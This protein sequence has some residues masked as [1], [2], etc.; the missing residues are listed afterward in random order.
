M[1]NYVLKSL[2][3]RRGRLVL[4]LVAVVLGVAFVA[5]SLLFTGQLRAQ[6]A[7]LTHGRTPD[8]VVAPRGALDPERRDA[9]AGAYSP[10][11]V[12][13]VANLPG[14]RAAEGVLTVPGVG[15]DRKD[16]TT[17]VNPVAP[18][19]AMGWTEFTVATGEPALTLA[20]GRAPAAG[21]VVLDRATWDAAGYR[22]GDRVMFALPVDGMREVALRV[23]GVGD[24]TAGANETQTVFVNPGQ[25][26][27]WVGDA[28]RTQI[29]AQ[30]GDGADAAVVTDAID[31]AL[32]GSE[33]LTA[34][35][36]ADL[37]SSAQADALSFLQPLLL[38]FAGIALV[39]ACFLIVNTFSILVLQRT[40]ELALLRALGASRGQV[41]RIVVLEA[42][43]VGLVGS[44]LG[45]LAGWGLAAGLLALMG[46]SGGLALS[47]PVLMTGIGVGLVVTLLASLPPARRA[48]RIAPVVAM[49]GTG[50]NERRAAPRHT[51]TDE[52]PVFTKPLGR[53]A[54]LN[55][56][57]RPGRTVA[58]A[59]TL[60]IGLFLV[61]TLGT[62]G[63]SMKATIDDLMPQVMTSDYMVSAH[64]GIGS[65][66][67]ARIRAIDGVGEVRT[68]EM[69]GAGVGDLQTTVTA[70][71][72]EAYGHPI[73]QTMI[74]GRPAEQPGELVVHEPLLADNGWQ[75][76][77]H[78]PGMVNGVEMTWT[79]VG[80][81]AY[82]QNISAGDFLTAPATLREL[83]IPEEIA[84]V[85]V[86]AR[87]GA[88]VAAI[89]DGLRTATRQVSGAEVI[90]LV[91][92][93]ELAGA[94]INAL[95]GG[96]Y[97]LIALSVLIA[98]LGIVNT[99]G[100]SVVERTR[101]LGL[102]RA[103]GMTRG[104]VRGLIVRESLMISVIGGTVGIGL[105]V[106]AGVGLRS[107]ISD[108]MTQLAIPWA[109][110]GIVLA[111]I[112]VI[113]VVAALGP[114]VR[115]ARTRVLEAIAA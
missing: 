28:G 88:D 34:A 22:L 62:L 26:E 115:A 78:L 45:V 61:G 94:Q 60:T 110:I 39:V 4:S 87:E 42:L 7:G 68:Y 30:L 41:G 84:M 57:R 27:G 19:V 108:Q 13:R 18:A 25:L 82:P 51:S 24:W 67:L 2:W 53:L 65:E 104:Q 3:G 64:Q 107:A 46:G 43:A 75:L 40:R 72:P 59:L 20:E 49:S 9:A 14:V 58:T 90:G 111:L 93:S 23:V 56:A 81:F 77:T 70:A 15:F 76:G 99:L 35:E 63:A 32:P 86:T 91:E 37:Q 114:A 92:Y 80:T 101:E 31:R 85:T 1:N 16:G 95:V 79:V 100:L 69:T 36:A 106:L 71:R 50:T 74:D 52:P 103:V 5:G 113:G 29:W 12:S 21:E 102:L 98:A 97:A 48:G 105:G 73:R 109:Q 54:R 33:A 44:V 6:Y 112:V 55:A 89:G 10:S 96:V 17:A 83:G 47:G 8:I 38:V 11:D 66:Q